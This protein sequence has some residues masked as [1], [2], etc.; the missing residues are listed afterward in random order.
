MVDNPEI[1]VAAIDNGLAF[2]YK[3]PDEWR[4]YPY[5]WAWLP[6]AKVPF[7]KEIQDLLLH[8][9]EDNNFVQDL[10]D[11]ILDL[12]SHDKGFDRPTFEK[13]IA[14]MR[15]QIYNLIEALKT[16][17]SPVDLVKMPVY[18]LHRRRHTMGRT[19]ADSD[20]F[21]RSFPRRTPFFSW[22]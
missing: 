19:R 4:A 5:H 11:D 22:C 20:N 1:A 8:K 16:Q 7:S 15:G 9:L 2:P 21:T 3:H 10:C 13:Q 17:M 12:F 14:V 6:Q 18:T